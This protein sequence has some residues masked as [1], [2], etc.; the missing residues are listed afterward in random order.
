VHADISL[1]PSSARWPRDPITVRIVLRD[2][3]GRP[4]SQQP[5]V[6]TDVRVNLDPVR[7]NWVQRGSALEGVLAP[8][9]ENGPWS[10]RVQVK[11]EF[12]EEIG[13]NFLQVAPN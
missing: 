10:V 12:G 7:L 1:G 13:W 11:D 3:N 5:K 9:R 6:V 2:G 8:R 4:L